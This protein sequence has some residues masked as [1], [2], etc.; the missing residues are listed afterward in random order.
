MDFSNTEILRLATLFGLVFLNITLALLNKRAI[1]SAK[2][3]LL[4][5]WVR[6]G[7]FTLAIAILLSNFLLGHPFW[8]LCAMACLCFFLAETLIYWIMIKAINHSEL[9]KHRFYSDCENAWRPEPELLK[10]KRKLESLSFRKIGSLR[11]E[12]DKIDLALMTV[13]SSP[14]QKIRLCIVFSPYGNIWRCSSCAISKTASGKIIYTEASQIPFGLIYP[15]NFDAQ[16]HLLTSNPLHLLKIHQ[17]RINKE[18]DLQELT[19]PPREFTNTIAKE[20]ESYN[21]M[22]GLLNTNEEEDGYLTLDGR[23]LV[24]RDMIKINYF[25]F[26]SD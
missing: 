3:A 13:F 20:I 16:R 2:I 18:S 6:C 8:A 9:I 1:P 24:W 12:F 10:L 25:P 17:N 23:S 19:S 7:I 5:R 22:R 26:I 11:C 4:N 15:E 14:E 21:K